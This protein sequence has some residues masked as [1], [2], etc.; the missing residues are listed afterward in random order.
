MDANKIVQQDNTPIVVKEQ[1]PAGE[2]VLNEIV[3]RPVDRTP[4]DIEYWR[5]A[6]IA[7]ERIVLPNRTRLYDL[8]KDVE[9][10]GHLTGVIAKRNA[11]VKNKK[12]H[13]Y[14]QG[15]KVDKM[16]ELVKK[17]RFR[18][19]IGEIIMSSK[20]HGISGVEFKVGS[21]FDWEEI[22]RKHIKPE[23]GIISIEQFGIEGFDYNQLPLVWVVGGKK[24]FG[25]LLKC[26]PY[27]LFKRG[28]MADWS[29]F[30]EIF[31][32]PMRIAKYDSNDVKTKLELKYALDEAGSAVV[33]MVPKG[34]DIEIVDGKMSNADGSIYKNLKD[35]CDEEMSV[36]VVGVTET[37][38]S[39]SS[40]G[41]AQSQTHEKQQNEIIKDDL[42][43]VAAILN[44]QKFSDILR[45]YGYPV[46]DGG[47]WQFEEDI[48]INKMAQK[49]QIDTQVAKQVPI[50]DDYWYQTYK[51]E[52]PENYAELRAKMDARLSPGPGQQ[53]GG[54]PTPPDP[55]QEDTPPGRKKPKLSVKDRFF[56]YL[57][58]FFDPAR[59]D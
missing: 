56:L 24:D 22:D 17:K 40:S 44:D 11:A 29:Q 27:A 59:E 13:Y 4:K 5:N 31:G 54:S 50:G 53:G 47:E 19:L 39:S 46:Q 25:Y 28:T 55:D 48:D 20:S 3:V 35:A 18:D 45:S 2:M 1:L 12:L 36:I 7:A 34:C 9:L 49:V 16:D 41:Y 52:K 58:D 38:T 23:L 8:Y 32:M 14:V 37:T 43:D 30:S 33:M 21:E 42:A 10:D 57:A 51:I 6:H 15:Q 26:A